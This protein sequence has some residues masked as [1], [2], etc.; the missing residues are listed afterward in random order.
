MNL[1]Y[2][3]V[4][5]VG[6]ELASYIDRAKKGRGSGGILIVVQGGDERKRNNQLGK[7]RACMP[8]RTPQEYIDD[9]RK[10]KIELYMLGER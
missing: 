5:G 1:Q 7:E 4:P 6:T 2:Y 3:G 8:L 9:L 10:M